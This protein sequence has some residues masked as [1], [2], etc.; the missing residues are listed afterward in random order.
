MLAPYLFFTVGECCQRDGKGLCGV[1]WCVIPSSKHSAP[2]GIL[3]AAHSVE[4]L[5]G[6]HKNN[7][8]INHPNAVY[9]PQFCGFRLGA[10]TPSTG[11]LLYCNDRGGT[12]ILK[13]VLL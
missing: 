10:M 4:I 8:E 7:A 5:S 6:S 3:C 9:K 13:C 12:D 11:Y 2:T 1:L